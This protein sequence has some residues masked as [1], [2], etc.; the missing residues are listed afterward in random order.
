[1]KQDKLDTVNHGINV[2]ECDTIMHDGIFSVANFRWCKLL[3]KKDDFN[4]HSREENSRFFVVLHV[5]QPHNLLKAMW[6]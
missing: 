3:T 1:M 2:F 5:L 4:R 6:W